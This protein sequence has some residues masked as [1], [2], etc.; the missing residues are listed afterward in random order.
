MTDPGVAHLHT[1]EAVDG[2]KKA[3]QVHPRSSSMKADGG[4]TL[5][6]A[7]SSI[8]R[9][10]RFTDFSK[11]IQSTCPACQLV[12]F[13][14]QEPSYLCRFYVDNNLGLFVQTYDFMTKKGR[15]HSVGK[16]RL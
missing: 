3:L 2:L 7:E 4:H 16:Y 15:V 10:S 1:Q 14:S 12:A 9:D 11:D 5:C 8:H 6:G 13:T